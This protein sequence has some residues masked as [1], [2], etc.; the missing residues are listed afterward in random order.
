M[1][2]A[3]RADASLTIGTGHVMRCLTLADALRGH[4]ADCVFLSRDHAGHL[5][6]LVEARGYPLLSLGAVDTVIGREGVSGY[7]NWLG[8]D[9]QRD[10]DD[11]VARIAGLSVDWMVV[12]HYGLDDLWE[13]ALRPTCGR[14]M[15]IDDLANRDHVVDV[16]L[17][18]NLG[19]IP[20][21][22]EDRVPA[23]CQLMLGPRYALLRPEFAAL[24]TASLSR[25]QEGRPRKLLVTMG[26]VDLENAT[27]A[28]LEALNAWGPSANLHVTIVMGPSA[29]W[30]DKVIHQTRCLSFPTEVLVNVQVMG[31]LM[32]NADLA[33]GAAGSTSWERCCLGL[34][35]LQIVLAENQRL[36]ANALSQAGAAH[37]LERAGLGVSLAKA[38]D[39]LVRDPALLLRMSTAAAILVD[40]Q[41][42]ERIAQ[43]LKEGL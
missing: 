37:L 27:G 15:A 10:A 3:F 11:T 35:T 33:I 31:D 32:C 6:Q 41:G 40:G 14:I 18:Q 25:R 42:T 20:A 22:Y 28:V 29:P 30:R 16:L 21:D 26:G 36:I 34:P 38:M 39:Q 12:D 2:V 1:K 23:S 43:Y 8:V 7:A 17:D 13:H 5:H 9:P 24:R 4:G 19:K